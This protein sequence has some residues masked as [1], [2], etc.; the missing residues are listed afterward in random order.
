M[1]KPVISVYTTTVCPYCV[2]AKR[3]FSSLSLPFEE[4]NLDDKPELRA[5]LSAENNGWRTVPMIF[6]RD[7]F[8]G[9]FDDVNALHQAGKL[10][11]LV[12]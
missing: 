3:L 9:G 1:S 2:A 10:L 4:I 6:I 5:K 12:K 8:M 11:P 7:K